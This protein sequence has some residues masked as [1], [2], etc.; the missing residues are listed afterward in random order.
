MAGPQ[1]HSTN[2]PGSF[3]TSGIAGPYPFGAAPNDPAAF[4]SVNQTFGPSTPTPL[5]HEKD[6]FANGLTNGQLTSSLMVR[7]TKNPQFDSS[8]GECIF[9][10]HNNQFS[11]VSDLSHQV[12]SVS[13]L[14]RAMMMPAFRERYGSHMSSQK[15]AEDF[16]FA[17]IQ[18]WDFVVDPRDSTEVITVICGGIV[19]H[20]YN[21]WQAAPT[22][23]RSSLAI[24]DSAEH[25]RARGVFTRYGS[26]E[27][28]DHLYFLWIRKLYTP[29][30]VVGDKRKLLGAD[31]D[32][33]A[34]SRGDLEE[35]EDGE[36]DEK[37]SS[38]VNESRRRTND[39]GVVHA[40][41]NNKPESGTYMWQ[42]V[43][44]VGKRGDA[45]PRGLYN[46]TNFRGHFV[47]VG[48]VHKLY[49]NHNEA[50]RRL[51]ETARR[52]LFPKTST[53]AYRKDLHQL[54]H[55]SIQLY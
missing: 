11:T 35:E 4:Q 54:N 42:V 5:F 20:V 10:C 44:Y 31:L 12:R 9:T 15:V 40:P 51:G 14:N 17:G 33:N 7:L 48:V 53:D 19:E 1:V 25:R 18:D 8:K 43:P 13:S 39:L 21:Y 37:G 24:T 45:P 28:G 26:T 27:I 46:N 36:N 23:D 38:R 52:A 29:Q 34:R 32:K 47:H 3:P 50:A 55:V 2:F 30:Y 16:A 22:W 49:L 41:R 6:S